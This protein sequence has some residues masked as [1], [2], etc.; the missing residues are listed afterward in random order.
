MNEAHNF[1]EKE[2]KIVKCKIR[3]KQEKKLELR[4][5]IISKLEQLS[6]ADLFEKCLM[7]WKNFK[8]STWLLVFSWTIVLKGHE[9]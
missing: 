1:N 6:R 5:C 4:D 7:V 8:A 3:N 9:L 2:A